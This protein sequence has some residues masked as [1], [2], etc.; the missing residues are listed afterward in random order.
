M[1]KN[2]LLFLF[3]RKPMNFLFLGRGKG[4]WLGFC[5]CFLRKG[6]SM[7]PPRWPRTHN[8]SVLAY[9]LAAGITG[10]H[11]HTPVIALILLYLRGEMDL[12]QNSRP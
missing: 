9:L 10:V 2:I 6:L 4:I 7:D 11:H 12:I 5:F 1:V 8:F 3:F